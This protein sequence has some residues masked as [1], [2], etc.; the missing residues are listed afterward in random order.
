MSPCHLCCVVPCLQLGME[1]GDIIDC[2]ME[3]IGG[4]S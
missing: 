3:Q 2:F 1:D 4:S